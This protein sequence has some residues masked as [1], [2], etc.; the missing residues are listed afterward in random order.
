MITNLLYMTN[1][2]KAK[3]IQ[4]S[5]YSKIFLGGV[6]LKVLLSG[7]DSK[8]YCAANLHK[9]TQIMHKFAFQKQLIML[10][11]GHSF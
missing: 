2:Y 9:Q 3:I 10:C 1:I 4:S 8:L 7:V 11:L 6:K 5:S